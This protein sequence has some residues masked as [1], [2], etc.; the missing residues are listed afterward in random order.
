MNYKLKSVVLHITD[1]CSSHCPYC[2][3]CSKDHDV[4]HANYDLLCN[5]VDKI[6]EADVENV[7]LLGGDPVLFPK[8]SELVKYIKSKEMSVSVMSNT[9]DFPMPIE[10]AVRDIDVFETTIHGENSKTHDCFCG[11]PGAYDNLLAGLRALSRH[12]AKIGVAI[13]IIPT[14]ASSLYDILAN[15]IQ[16]EKIKIDYVILQRIIPFGRAKGS[17]RYSLSNKDINNALKAVLQAKQDFKI[18]IMVEDPFPLCVIDKKYYSIMHPCEWGYTKAALNGKGD[19]T[20]CGADPRYLLG[21][22]FETPLSQIWASS[23]L[24]EQFRKKAHLPPFCHTCEMLEQCGGGCPLS[25]TVGDETGFDHLVMK[26][27]KGRNQ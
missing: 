8:I 4:S 21:N 7:S 20:R 9:M 27:G 17:D 11:S 6:K 15:L 13:N 19:V 26:Y 2:Y 25:N 18:A 10:E 23:P 12:N 1:A 22:V 5:V 16:V 3:A 24:L 14:T